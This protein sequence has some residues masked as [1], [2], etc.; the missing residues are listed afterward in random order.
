L[1]CS[2]FV[3]VS[4]AGRCDGGG[5]TVE[6]GDEVGHLL[7]AADPVGARNSVVASDQHFRVFAASAESGSQ[8]SE[9]GA[10]REL[11]RLGVGPRNPLSDQ[12]AEYRAPTG[13]VGV[14]AASRS[15][16]R[17]RCSARLKQ[18][19]PLSASMLRRPAGVGSG[20][21]ASI[22]VCVGRLASRRLRSG[23]GGDLTTTIHPSDVGS[24][25]GWKSCVV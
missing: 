14:Q 4:I 3:G 24:Y 21:H 1:S 13:V 5:V 22:S 7:V 16:A 6:S 17:A 20:R 18:R 19:G 8:W 15:G 23:P 10:E 2:K 11:R 25:R 12:A 9:I